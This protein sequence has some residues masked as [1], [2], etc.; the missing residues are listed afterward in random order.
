MGLN[1]RQKTDTVERRRQIVESHNAEIGQRI[2]AVTAPAAGGSRQQQADQKRQNRSANPI[3]HTHATEHTSAAGPPAAPPKRGHPPIR[4]A[5]RR[6]LANLPTGPTNRITTMSPTPAVTPETEYPPD[7]LPRYCDAAMA[8]CTERMLPHIVR[9]M[10]QHAFLVPACEMMARTRAPPPVPTKL[11]LASKATPIKG[12]L[13]VQ[14]KPTRRPVR[15]Q[16][17]ER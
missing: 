6:K 17:T 2:G 9:H 4:Y 5:F 3:P 12:D 7:V 11:H 14:P 13:H 10:P 16:P 15:I 1:P 8:L